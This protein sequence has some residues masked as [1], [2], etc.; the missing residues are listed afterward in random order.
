[1]VMAVAAEAA[2]N[3]VVINTVKM[4]DV[5]IEITSCERK[6][7]TASDCYCILLF[8]KRDL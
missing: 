1:M 4:T 8:E 3:I 2:D 6:F 5:F 7:S